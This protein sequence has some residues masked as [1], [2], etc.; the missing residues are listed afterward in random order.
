MHKSTAALAR[1]G[2]DA[3][4]RR[5]R[6]RRPVISRLAI[7]S[8]GKRAAFCLIR[9]VSATGAA[10]KLYGQ[11]PAAPSVTL[12]VGDE[13]PLGGRI[14]WVRG[15]AAGISFSSPLEPQALHRVQQ[16]QP[17][18]RRRSSPRVSA[19][20][21]VIVKTGGRRYAGELRD[22][23]ALG[24]KVRTR[25]PV[26]P[27]SFVVLVLPGMPLMKAFVRWADRTELGLSFD[28]PLP[29]QVIAG[30]LDERVNVSG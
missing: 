23:S 6:S 19:V 27:G 12:Q 4:E 24:A 25:R 22:I 3:G 1:T 30:W 26:N 15:D 20:A 10:V 18:I 2:H 7:L 21:Q 17:P 13:R 16:K 8:D 29:I 14:A 11:I 28:I 5:S 9:N